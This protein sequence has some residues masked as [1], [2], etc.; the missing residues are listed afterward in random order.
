M[1]VSKAYTGSHPNASTRGHYLLR[2]VPHH[3]MGQPGPGPCLRRRR[4]PDPDKVAMTSAQWRS[5]RWAL[6]TG[7]N[8]LTDDKRALVNQIA[9]ANRRVGRAWTLKEQLRDLYRLQHEPGVARQRLKAWITAAKRS[10][11]TV[12]RRTRQ[13]PARST[14]M[15]SLPPSN[16]ASP[17]PSSK[18]STP[19]SASS[20]PAAT[21]T[22]PPKP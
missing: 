12:L 14:S 20:T 21:A 7:E 19:K 18:A 9:R 16:S 6:R 10:R 11:I 3:A 8:K 4:Q 15:P 17:T 1:D 5:T 2:P 22:T 13:T